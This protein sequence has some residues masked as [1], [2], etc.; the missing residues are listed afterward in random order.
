[1]EK[2]SVIIP[3]HNTDSYLN[4]C[5]DSVLN[6]TLKEIEIIAVD[7]GSDDR[8]PEILESYRINNSSCFKVV[9]SDVADLSSARNLGLLH[10]TGE[11]IAY[12]DSDDY[13]HPKTYEKMY[14]KAQEGDYDM[15]VCDIIYAYPNRNIKVL[16]G[17]Q[18]DKTS[19]SDIRESITTIHPAAWNKLF[20]RKIVTG[21]VSFTPYIFFEDF[22]FLYR[23]Y[24]YINSIGVVREPLIFY[25]QREGSITHVFDERLYS[26]VKNFDN[27]ID[28]YQQ[29]GCF[30]EY[31][32]ELEYLYVRYAY[33]TMIK[34]MSLMRNHK[35]YKIGVAFA[36]KSVNDT[37]PKFRRNSLF[38][39]SA[40]GFYLLLF[41]CFVAEI[42]YAIYNLR[43]QR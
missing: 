30:E 23:V 36:C 41:N 7:N 38:Y 1:M 39:H 24:P 34:R 43:K 20:K 32:R 27:I 3:V 13:V 28:H 18:K 2:V 40:K 25:R 29:I 17:I 31:H 15:V 21:E 33:A 42:I 35:A 10:A 19:V 6:Q 37:F 12:L 8:S 11:Y 4:Q 22:E 9:N 16:S 14:T 5:I 26:F